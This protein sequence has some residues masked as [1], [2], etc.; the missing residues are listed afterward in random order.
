MIK[1]EQYI[2][3]QFKFLKLM[4]LLKSWNGMIQSPV[5]DKYASKSKPAASAMVILLLNR[6]YSQE[7]NTQGFRDM[8]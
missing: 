3:V 5:R 2:C 1:K 6:D 4:E 8:K 7:S